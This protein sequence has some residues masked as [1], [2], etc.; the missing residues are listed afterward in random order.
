MYFAFSPIFIASA[1]TRVVT[2]I[3]IEPELWLLKVQSSN[4]QQQHHMGTCQKCRTSG[5]TLDWI[6]TRFSAPWVMHTDAR[7][8]EAQLCLDSFIHSMVILNIFPLGAPWEHS[9]YEQWLTE[10]K[11]TLSCYVDPLHWQSPASQI[12]YHNHNS[13]L[14][15]RLSSVWLLWKINGAILIGEPYK[16]LWFSPQYFSTV[17]WHFHKQLKE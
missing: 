3:D 6:R 12:T 7:V 16:I 14:G 5:P 13:W 10:R 8:W 1:G 4:Q 9:R 11:V 2:G 15:H 17:V